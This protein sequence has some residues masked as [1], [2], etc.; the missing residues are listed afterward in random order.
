MPDEEAP[1]VYADQ[2][3]VSNNIWGTALTFLKAPPHPA[4]GQTPQA[5]RQVTV[6]M[7]LQHA[8]VVAM[9]LRKTL[10]SW[11]RENVEIAL[12]HAV[13]NAMQLSAED[14]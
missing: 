8:K 10:K 11:E 7:S 4:P 2:F 5:E 9:L 1:D 13:L 6:R 12:P 14:W 3:I